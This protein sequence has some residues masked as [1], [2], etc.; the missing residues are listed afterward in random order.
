MHR[1]NFLA[2]WLCTLHWSYLAVDRGDDKPHS[3]LEV[4]SV[5]RFSTR[6]KQTGFRRLEY[7]DSRPPGV[8]RV[9]NEL[10]TRWRG[11]VVDLKHP[12]HRRDL[13]TGIAQYCAALRRRG[14]WNRFV[15]RVARVRRTADDGSSGTMRVLET[16]LHLETR[17][18]LCGLFS[19]WEKGTCGTNYMR[20]SV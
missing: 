4:S 3:S 18:R 17:R 13:E 10:Q 1:L 12:S 16:R 6:H 19:S 2:A 5:A 7:C 15:A 20:V 9:E 14:N 11:P 8:F